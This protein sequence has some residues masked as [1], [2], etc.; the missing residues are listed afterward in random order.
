MQAMISLNEHEE[1]RTKFEKGFR[2]LRVLYEALQ[3]DEFL[4]TLQSYESTFDEDTV[5]ILSSDSEFLRLLNRPVE[6][7]PQ[8]PGGSRSTE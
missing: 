1:D 5:L 8:P 7:S 6:E 4:R 3:P 2:N